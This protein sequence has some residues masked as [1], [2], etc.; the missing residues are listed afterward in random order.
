MNDLVVFVS[1]PA[2]L[3]VLIISFQVPMLLT[4][5][6][7][8]LLTSYKLMTC[9]IISDIANEMTQS[10]TNII[11]SYPKK[12]TNITGKVNIFYYFNVFGVTPASSP[13]LYMISSDG[14][15]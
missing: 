3:V 6:I 13:V 12:F 1:N 7:V 5:V 14:T 4:M 10:F 15:N 8:A 2:N 11:N 9:L